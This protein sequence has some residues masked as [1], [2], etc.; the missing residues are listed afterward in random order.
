MHTCTGLLSVRFGYH[1]PSGQ[2]HAQVW[3]SRSRQGHAESFHPI[4]DRT[5]SGQRRKVQVIRGRFTEGTQCLA[6]LA[7]LP[8]MTSTP[9]LGNGSLNDPLNSP[10]DTVSMLRPKI[11]SESDCSDNV[12]REMCMVTRGVSVCMSML[13]SAYTS[14]IIVAARHCEC[15]RVWS[16]SPVRPWVILVIHVWGKAV[17][18]MIDVDYH[19]VRPL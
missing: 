8:S 15:V 16:C 9:R 7:A 13:G 5:L 10:G 2:G 17:S 19:T 18:W 11:I 3:S 12:L 4:F 14:N 6:T 1:G